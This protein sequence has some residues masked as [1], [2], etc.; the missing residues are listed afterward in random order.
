MS[1][2]SHRP[3]WSERPSGKPYNLIVGVTAELEQGNRTSQVPQQLFDDFGVGEFP[4]G[5]IVA[6]RVPLNPEFRKTGES[7]QR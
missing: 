4:Q 1:R 5:A 2:R 6:D 3:A 7:R